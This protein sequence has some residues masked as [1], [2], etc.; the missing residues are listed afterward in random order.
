MNILRLLLAPFARL[1]RKRYAYIWTIRAVQ[2]ACFVVGGIAAFLLRFDFS[3]PAPWR[4]AL[5]AG[6]AI[7]VLSKV[8]VFQCC[9]LGNGM[10]RYFG[11]SDLMRVAGAS[12]AATLLATFIA[13]TAGPP[14]FPRS[15]LAIDFLL[16]VLFGVS[17]RAG[18]RLCL[19]IASRTRAAHQR[20]ALIYGAGST[21]VLLLN[22]ARANPA[23]QRLICGFVDDDPGKQ[24]MRV[25][26]VPVRGGG[27]NLANLVA[28]HAV[29]EVLIAIP[30]ADG[31][32]M[33]RIIG[34]C[35]GAGVP[36]R[37]MPAIPEL[38]A[39]RGMAAQIRDVAMEDI[40]GRNAVELDRG[41][42]SAKLEGSVALVT[43][44]GGSIG[45]ELCRQIAAFRPAALVG[46]EIAETALFHL[47]QEM[48]RQFPAV[49][50]YPEIG[51]IQ[52]PQRLREVFLKYRP[53]AIYHAAAYKHVPLMETH[54]VEAVE[55]NIFGTYQAALAAAE[56]GAEDFVMISSDKAVNPANVMGA[57]KRVAE[58]VVRSLQNGGPKYLSVRFG[59]VLG[60]NGSVVPTFQ[61]QIASGGPVTITH[62]E[63][64]RYFMTIPE[65]AQLVLEAATIGQGGEIFVL[66]MGKP[67]RI[68]DLARQLIS[69]SGLRPGE[70]IAIEFTGARPGEKLY[71]ELSLTQEQTMPTR[72]EKIRVFA[73]ETPS[74]ERMACHLAVLRSAC[75]RR[76]R[77]ALL[78]ELQKMVPDYRISQSVMQW[79]PDASLARLAA[80]V[81]RESAKPGSGVLAPAP[82]VGA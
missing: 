19:E 8:T 7:G 47:E 10:W 31:E 37:T 38:I 22:E 74:L 64:Q 63:M 12:F 65:A 32:A 71:E 68:L 2:L 54:V 72:H 1:M 42:I 29:E 15:V 41:R 20:R 77:R 43:G 18:T 62:P 60:S 16:S 58:L 81:E 70:D 69:L 26:G 56:A 25:N 27:A 50:F 57:T 6:V 80:A 49:R 45:S 79:L 59:N 52:N 23:F 4:H 82:A 46:F 11:L 67:V 14:H 51:S 3:V 61:R 13:L 75:E 30:S 28:E 48:A 76:D 55:N 73:G 34:Y 39:G 78:L 24:D 36:F 53:R 9:G 40:L 44:A 5:W 33:R 66:D 21:G 35:Q 17:L